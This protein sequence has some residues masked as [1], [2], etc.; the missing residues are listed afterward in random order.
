MGDKVH[1]YTYMHCCLVAQ[2]P[3]SM[4]FSRP[5]YWRL[6]F[7]SPGNFSVPR[8]ELHLLYWQADSLLLNHVGSPC[9][10]TCIHIFE[11]YVH[12][13]IYVGE[14]NGTPLQYCCLENPMDGG[15]WQAAVHGVSKSQ[16]RLN[17]F[18]FTFHFHALEKE[19]E[20]TPVFLPGESHGQRSLVGC[21]PWDRRVGH[22]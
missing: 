16:T 3:L 21:S 4:V 18:T 14:G 2:G 20:P 15:A 8:I 9:T 19:M 17:D 11:I 12:L 5:E 7:P 10:C 22:D 13:C 6:P 1:I